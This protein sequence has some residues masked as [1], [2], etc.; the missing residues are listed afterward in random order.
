VKDQTP[1]GD[2]DAPDMSNTPDRSNAPDSPGCPDDSGIPAPSHPP[3]GA[4]PPGR[5]PP[6]V[7]PRVRGYEVMGLLGQGGMGTVWRATQLGTGRQVALK[8]VGTADPACPAWIDLR[9]Q[10][11]HEVRLAASLE[12]PN[13]ARVYDGGLHEGVCFYAM[14]LVEGDHLD[15]HARRRALSRRQVVRLLRAVCDAVAY[16]HARNVVHRDLKPANILVGRDGAPRVV[17]FGLARAA[18]DLAG[19]NREAGNTAEVSS[20]AAASAP[21]PAATEAAG[22]AAGTAMGKAAG[23]PAFM[24]PLQRAGTA[25]DARSDVYSL[26]VIL[27]QLAAGDTGGPLD[28]D[29]RAVIDKAL[30]PARDDRYPTSAELGADL[31]NYL[32]GRPL[33]ARPVQAAP[34][35]SE[36]KRFP[37]PRRR[38]PAFRLVVV[39]GLVVSLTLFLALRWARRE[40]RGRRGRR[41]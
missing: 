23:T 25:A 10:F 39:A 27:Y 28:A 9:R 32:D 8:V 38:W 29:L 17:D 20:P 2:P 13:I 34:L 21:T 37:A 6:V 26:G 7:P 31:Q 22:T 36:R 16:A 4:A 14:E 19:E 18:S 33:I 30:A 41:R 5:R 35:G 40:T 3:G 12:H 24:S 1:G 11:E 15:R